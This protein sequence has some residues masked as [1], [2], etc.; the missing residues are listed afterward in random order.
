MDNKTKIEIRDRLFNQ[1]EEDERELAYLE[2]E[3]G[4]II[5]R[6]LFLRDEIESVRRQIPDV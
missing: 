6:Y 3:Y 5:D 4:S 1:L 2:S